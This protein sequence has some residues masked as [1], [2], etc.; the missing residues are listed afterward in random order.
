M[1]IECVSL[2]RTVTQSP[3]STGIHL[4]R[5]GWSP[6]TWMVTCK[7]WNCLK[8]SHWYSPNHVPSHSIWS[9]LRVDNSWRVIIY[10]LLGSGPVWRTAASDILSSQ[11]VWY[12]RLQQQRWHQLDNEEQGS[13]YVWTTGLSV[14]LHLPVWLSAPPSPLCSAST[15]VCHWHTV[16]AFTTFWY[17]MA[18]TYPVY[19][20]PQIRGMDDWLA[21]DGPDVASGDE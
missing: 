15:H 5:T 19:S 8:E 18:A 11:A 6:S 3:R 4:T 2:Q 16:W 14:C 21:I 1:I 13:R 9:E 20:G 12:V 7:T 17:S 10:R